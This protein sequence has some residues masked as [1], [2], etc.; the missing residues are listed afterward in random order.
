MMTRTAAAKQS[1]PVASASSSNAN[2]DSASKTKDSS[3]LIEMQQSLQKA[4]EEMTRVERPPNDPTN[5]HE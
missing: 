1:R 3:V 5:G 2:P 4:M